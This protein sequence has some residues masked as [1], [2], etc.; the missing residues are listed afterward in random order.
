MAGL[1]IHIPFCNEKCVY[2]DF[3]SGNQLYLIDIYVEAICSEIQLR[4]DYLS[5]E[6][7][8]TIYL[9]GGTPSLLSEAHLLKIF[10]AIHN[11]L[12][13]G[14]NPEITIECNPEN[15]SSN[16]VNQLVGLGVNRISLG[17]QFLLDDILSNFNRR[18]SKSLIFNS[19]D[20]ISNSIISNLSIDLIYAV[21]GIDNNSLLSSLNQLI[22]FDIKH[23]S[24]YNLTVGKNSKLYWKV[25]NG[26]YT[27]YKEDA[28]I[29][30][31]G[32]IHDF[33]TVSGFFQYEISNYA[34]PGFIS[35]HNLAY[36]NQVP[37][38]GVGVSAHSYNRTSRQWNKT[39]IKKYIR[40][41]ECEI[42]KVDFEIEYLTDVQLY[43][44]YVILR[45]RTFQGLSFSYVLL[46]FGVNIS[47]HFDKT[48]KILRSH[49]HFD[50][51]GD[52][53][54]PTGSDLLIADYL[55]KSLMI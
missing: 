25:E 22:K 51:Y 41:L 37:Y 2:C 8:D 52:N 17:V 40:E 12:S 24:A 49:T 42:P 36:W 29:A 4:S 43:N 35:K 16:Y 6:T 53:I 7:Y 39:N 1:Y 33:L 34:K 21:Q 13:V 48:I 11:C 28:F 14:S 45:L 20:I 30:Q 9:G 44:E 18:H 32:I 55:A 47:T 50:I 27:E 19:L 54:I 5:N 23:V 10:N 26:E 38:L 46:N 31:Y 3:Y 15:I